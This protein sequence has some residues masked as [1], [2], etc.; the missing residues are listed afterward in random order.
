MPD[1]PHALLFMGLGAIIAPI[2]GYIWFLLGHKR[3]D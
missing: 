1:I 3:Y 2:I